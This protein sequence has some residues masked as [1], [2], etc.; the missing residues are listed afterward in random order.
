MIACHIS[1]RSIKICRSLWDM[2]STNLLIYKGTEFCSKRKFK[3]LRTSFL[4]QQLYSLS[5]SCL[6]ITRRFLSSLITLVKTYHKESVYAQPQQRFYRRVC[7]FLHVKRFVQML[8][9][10]RHPRLYFIWWGLY[11]NHSSCNLKYCLQYKNANQKWVLY[12]HLKITNL[13]RKRFNI[14]TAIDTSKTLN[15]REKC[16]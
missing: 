6:F 10:L 16:N 8:P 4:A 3:K 2:Y 13:K 9:V 5:Y 14:W 7:S 11:T 1:C 15:T 12:Q